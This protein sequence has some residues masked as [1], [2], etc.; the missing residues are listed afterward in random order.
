MEISDELREQLREL[1][2]RVRRETEKRI[3]KGKLIQI[4]RAQGHHGK[5]GGRPRTL[6]KCKYRSHRYSPKTGKCYGCGFQKPN[7]D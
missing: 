5:K 4:A 7:A 6:P 2:K 3:G 1:G